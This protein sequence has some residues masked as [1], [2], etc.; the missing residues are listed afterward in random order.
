LDVI[1]THLSVLLLPLA[2]DTLLWFGPRL[3]VKELFTSTF[4][5]M[6]KVSNGGG[7]TVEEISAGREH[8]IQLFQNFNLL[9]FLR[10]FPV[11]VSSLMTAKM[12]IETPFGVRSVIEV[13]SEGN[14]FGWIL[15][16]T[17]IGWAVGGL[18]FGQVSS[19]AGSRKTAFGP[20]RSVT[21]T[22]LFSIV[23][24]VIMFAVG[25]PVLL[26]MAV[27]NLISPA[28]VQVAMFVLALIS[29][30]VIVPIFF[31][32]HGIYLHGQ[33][34][35]YS[36]YT[37][38]R[39]ARFTLPTSSMFVLAVFIISQGLNY[40][41]SVPPEESWMMLVGIAGH[42][43]VTTALLAASFIYYRDMNAWLEIVFER[44]KPGTA[45][46]QT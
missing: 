30:W 45:A 26:V 36:I 28:M 40:L 24:T 22:L 4:D 44:L 3:S 46:P 43:F 15:L 19:V 5:W 8:Y 13:S 17:L 2:L 33:N 16:L 25:V 38:L 12:P 11:G 6:I 14:L 1:S 9:N 34:A 39:M 27:I 20:G 37:S 23:F 35:I 18:Y 10:T 21:Q 32:P 29:A 41:W 42:A 7:F 31:A